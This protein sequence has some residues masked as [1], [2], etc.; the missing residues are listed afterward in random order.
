[1]KFENLKKKWK[2]ENMK[3]ENENENENEKKM[4]R[5]W[6][7]KWCNNIIDFMAY[8]NYIINNVNIQLIDM[9][10]PVTPCLHRLS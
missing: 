8:H 5:K 2:N 10:R 1:M 3:N 4:K 6:K 9:Y 7:M